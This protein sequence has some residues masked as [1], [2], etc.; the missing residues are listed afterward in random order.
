M[1]ASSASPLVTIAVPAYNEAEF[2]EASVRSLLQQSYP[3]IEILIADNG[4]T[5]ET[6]NICARLAAED[7]RVRTIRHPRNI[8]QNANFNYL[9]RVAAGTYFCWASAH[10]TLDPAFVETCVAALERH[11]DA[12]LAYPRTL[13]MRYDG[14]VTGEKK[15]GPFDVSAMPPAARF[16][17]VMWRVDCNIVYGLW[18][19]DAMLRSNLFQLVPAPDRVF[20]AEMA[21]LGTFVPADTA[22]YYRNNRGDTPQTEIEKRHRLMAYIWPSRRFTDA[23]LAGNNFYAPTVR[24]YRRAVLDARFGFLTQ[25]RLLFSVWL[26]GIVKSHLFPGADVLSAIARAVLPRPVQRAIMRR[27]QG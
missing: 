22:K 17:E 1:T 6:P 24:A 20:L 11:P 2:L 5:D 7:P 21:L 23:E 13:Y 4:S 15:R 18:R 3:H 8:G 16:R 26:A 12:V 14:T 10:D 19:T 9:P 27:I 25:R